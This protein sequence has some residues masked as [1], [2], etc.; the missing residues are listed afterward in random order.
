MMHRFTKITLTATVAMTL[1]LVGCGGSN[2]PSID[3]VKQDFTSP[4]GSTKDKASVAQAYSKQSN[5]SAASRV[6]GGG[7]VPGG[8]IAKPVGIEKLQARHMFAPLFEYLAA[9]AKG[10]Q[11]SGLRASQDAGWSCFTAEDF[12]SASV[13]GDGTSGSF[14]FSKDLSTCTGG[15]LTGN[16]SVDAEF[17]MDQAAGSFTYK[18]EEELSAVCETSGAKTCVTGTYVIEMEYG[19]AETGAFFAGWF[20]DVTWEEDGAQKAMQTKGGLR[21]NSTAT[22]QSLEYLVYVKD[23]AGAEHSLV[24]TVKVNG[25]GTTTIT[26]RGTDGS[27]DCTIQADGSGSCTGDLTWDDAYVDSLEDNPELS[28]Y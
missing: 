27:I 24:F 12:S 26:V 23:E 1:G 4:S 6:V 21:L 7:F 22:E 18:M 2:A 16:M 8:L 11:V 19:G 9:R 20:L 10:V 28:E 15:E 5:S 13:S 25:E 17:E 14:S 3:T